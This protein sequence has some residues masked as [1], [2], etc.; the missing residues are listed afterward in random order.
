MPQRSAVAEWRALA[1][2]GGQGE[3]ATDAGLRASIKS[4]LLKKPGDQARVGELLADWR[5]V[6]KAGAR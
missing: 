5:R 1:A 3:P 4:L 2:L 6:G